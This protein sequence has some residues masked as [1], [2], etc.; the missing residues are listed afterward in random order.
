MPSHIKTIFTYL[1]SVLRT[2]THLLHVYT[3]VR[4]KL[5]KVG[6]LPSCVSQQPYSG[7]Q[8]FIHWAILPS[9]IWYFSNSTVRGEEIANM[10]KGILFRCE[11]NAMGFFTAFSY[12]HVIL[13][14]PSTHPQS[15]LAYCT[16]LIAFL[17]DINKC[18]IISLVSPEKVFWK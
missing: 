3:E 9:L 16:L 14:T 18:S 6:Y 7:C 13:L 1:S 8:A 4:G 11:L 17:P 15:P 5:A 12:T 2:H 10:K